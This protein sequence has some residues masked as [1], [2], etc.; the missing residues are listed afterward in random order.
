MIN[1]KLHKVWAKCPRC[2]STQRVA[3]LGR[4]NCVF[5]GIPFLVNPLNKPSRIIKID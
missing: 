5:C 4:H 2:D 1:F 3:T